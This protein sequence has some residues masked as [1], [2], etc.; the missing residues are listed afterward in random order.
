MK[1]EVLVPLTNGLV[2]LCFMKFV[3]N[4]GQEIVQEILVEFIRGVGWVT[5][6]FRLLLKPGSRLP[7][8][9][10]SISDDLFIDI[11]HKESS[12]SAPNRPRFINGLPDEYRAH[13]L[14]QRSEMVEAGEPAHVI[15]FKL[16]RY[17]F[18]AAVWTPIVS[19]LQN[20]IPPNRI[21]S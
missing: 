13:F 4:L 5:L 15:R 7:I 12:S 8:L 14:D 20:L 2:A 9:R 17:W 21:S 3:E 10:V 6:S 16:L 11:V 1:K 19:K 18:L